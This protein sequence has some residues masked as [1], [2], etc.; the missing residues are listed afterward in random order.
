[1]NNFAWLLAV[2]P[3][4]TADPQLALDCARKSLALGGSEKPAVWDT[5]AVA[6]A[7]AGDFPGAVVAGE[8]ARRLAQAA[9]ETLLVAEIDRRLAAFRS[10][11]AWREPAQAPWNTSLPANPPRRNPVASGE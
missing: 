5:L 10:G 4:Q 3:D 8:Q 2:D 9:G 7:N 11:R 1:M 6:L